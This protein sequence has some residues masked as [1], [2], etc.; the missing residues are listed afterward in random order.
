T[1]PR[2]VSHQAALNFV[3]SLAGLPVPALDRPVQAV[4]LE[5]YGDRQGIRCYLSLPPDS[6]EPVAA[7]LMTHI[8]GASVVEA[9]CPSHQWSFAVE[10]ALTHPYRPLRLGN[11]DALVATLL[12]A[13]GALD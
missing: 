4:V 7:H 9:E 3:R 10:L 8:P 6:S 11:P 13:F 2:E 1:F 5:I 12:S